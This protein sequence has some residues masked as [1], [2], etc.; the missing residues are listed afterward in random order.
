LT[1][2]DETAMTETG[3][4]SNGMKPLTGGAAHGKFSMREFWEAVEKRYYGPDLDKENTEEESATPLAP[5]ALP[6]P[7]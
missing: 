4:S 1:D 6:A 7:E 5:L 3:N 2:S